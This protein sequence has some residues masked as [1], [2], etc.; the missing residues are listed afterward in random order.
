MPP[1]LV[2]VKKIGET[3]RKKSYCLMAERS[4]DKFMTFSVVQSIFSEAD[5][6]DT[7]FLF[8]VFGDKKSKS[9]RGSSGMKLMFTIIIH[10]FPCWNEIT[11]SSLHDAPRSVSRVTT[12][13][14]D[15]YKRGLSVPCNF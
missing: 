2:S 3:K 15:D 10:A 7:L 13:F 8:T 6:A 11:D 1:W 9:L 12:S 5:A 14:R 4:G